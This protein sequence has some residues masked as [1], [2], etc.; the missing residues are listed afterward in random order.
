MT[1]IKRNKVWY[2]QT[3]I[4]GKTWRRSTGQ[5]D[6]RDAEKQAREFQGQVQLLRGSSSPSQSLHQAM[7]DEV[8]RL[9]VYVSAGEAQRAVETFR[10]FAKYLGKDVPLSRITTEVLERFQCERLKSRA[11][12]TVKKDFHFIYHMLKTADH[13]IAKPMTPRRGRVN[14]NRHFLADEVTRIL[15]HTPLH[16]RTLYLVLLTTGARL[17]ELLPSNRSAHRP[18]LKTEVDRD[19]GM[20]TIRSAKCQPG[21]TPEIR[22]A[23]L[24]AEIMD[25]IRTESESHGGPYV[26]LPRINP[27]RAFDRVLK[28]ARIEKHDALGRKATLHSF[29]HTYATLA[30]EAVG[31]NPFLVQKMLGHKYSGTT[32]QYCHPECP[33]VFPVAD[34]LEDLG[35]S[36]Q[37]RNA[38][39]CQKGC[40]IVEMAFS[41]AG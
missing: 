41:K 27:W 30:A 1:L 16:D 9:E 39:G 12:E 5:A 34:L 4:N 35:A 14:R 28:A 18:L 3:K 25:L 11:L 17:A 29:R 22:R 23:K 13:V 38:K 15:Q 26:F 36:P 2:Y 8:S 40:Q 24:P 20:V 31:H 37:D 32:A 7:A 10:V 21:S 6:R 19:A 33:S